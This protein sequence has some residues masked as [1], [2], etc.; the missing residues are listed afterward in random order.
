MSS[1]EI[2]R[3]TG[4]AQKS[5]WFVLQRLRFVMKAVRPGPMGEGPVEVDETWIGG[6]PKNMHVAKRLKMKTALH[7]YS[8]K[9]TVMGN[10]GSGDTRGPGKGHP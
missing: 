2:A 4:V 9:A 3:A 6:K 1:Y 8:E 5:A 10:A 7:G